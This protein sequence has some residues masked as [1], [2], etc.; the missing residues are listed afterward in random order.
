MKNG[1][2][3]CDATSAY[4]VGVRACDTDRI[5]QVFQAMWDGP[6]IEGHLPC[7][8]CVGV[9]KQVDVAPG[10]GTVLLQ[11]NTSKVMHTK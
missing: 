2:P 6:Q 4:L 9:V 3:C 1:T 11:E 5:E 10:E 8:Q 7:H